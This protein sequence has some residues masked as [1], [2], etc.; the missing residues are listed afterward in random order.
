MRKQ[1]GYSILLGL[2]ITLTVL[3]ILT[4]LPVATHPANVLGYRSL[5]TWVPWS[6]LILAALAG[7]SC[8]LRSRIFKSH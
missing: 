7:T 8:K 6:T 4:L 5:C 3:A 2:T 1:P